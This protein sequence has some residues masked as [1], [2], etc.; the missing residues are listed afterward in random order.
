[1]G[2]ASAFT[3][4]MVAIQQAA[5]SAFYLAAAT[6]LFWR[7]QGRGVL[8]ALVPM[9]K[10]G[11]TTYLMQTA[12]GVI[13]FY[14]IGFGLMGQLGSGVAVACGIAFFIAQVFLARAWLA[15]FSLGPVEWLWRSLTYFRLQPLQRRPAA[16]AAVVS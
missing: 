8:G 9:G 16:P 1:M 4:L 15:R 7:Q 13:V 6:L 11:L 5:L 3:V 10:M 14:G 2:Q 12:F